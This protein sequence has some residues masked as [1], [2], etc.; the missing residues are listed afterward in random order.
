MAVNPTEQYWTPIQ[1]ALRMMMNNGVIPPEVQSQIGP[2]MQLAQA[3]GVVRNFLP[4]EY[5]LRLP[6]PSQQGTAPTTPNPLEQF[7][8][9]LNA[10]MY[11]QSGGDQWYA[12]KYDEYLRRELLKPQIPGHLYPGLSPK[13]DPYSINPG[14]PPLGGY[15]QEN[16]YPGSGSIDRDD[17]WGGGGY[18][19]SGVPMSQIQPGLLTRLASLSPEPEVMP[20]A[21]GPMGNALPAPKDT[22]DEEYLDEMN[23]ITEALDR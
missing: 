8:A 10:N 16:W 6:M 23:Y 1:M 9:D 3:S 19:S 15:N 11:P 20:Q 22:D 14:D 2:L 7:D 17:H 12:D 21:P 18:P 4:D 13:D 5:A